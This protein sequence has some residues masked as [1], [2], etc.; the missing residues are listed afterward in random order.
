[1]TETLDA[2]RRLQEVEY[3]LAELRRGVQSRQR[4]LGNIDRRLAHSTANYEA[5][6]TE[7]RELRRKSDTLELEIKSRESEIVKL[8]E[9]LNKAKGNREYAAILTQIN[10]DKADNAKLEEQGLQ[11]LAQADAVMKLAEEIGAQRDKDQARREE[12]AAALRKYE[13]ENA[14]RKD[15]LQKQR[16]DLAFELPGEVYAT[17]RR[18]ADKLDGEALVEVEQY[19]PRAEEFTCAGCA[20]GVTLEQVN[21]IR[22]RGEIAVCQNCG[23]LLWISR[24]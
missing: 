1:M 4:V 14:A 7:A 13:Q 17:F 2:L 24:K 12:L 6:V 3:Q 16:E 19:N 21:A 23:R 9:A 22:N 10:T 20:M 11:A 15:E 18:A 8:R 5:K